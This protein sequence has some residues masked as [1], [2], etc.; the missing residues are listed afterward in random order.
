MMSLP[1]G[2][3]IPSYQGPFDVFRQRQWIR[4]PIP[5]T[6]TLEV[7]MI[8]MILNTSVYESKWYITQ[9]TK[10]KDFEQEGS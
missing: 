7:N 1:M 5:N 6:A 9:S 3:E 8:N 2:T 4:D 10:D